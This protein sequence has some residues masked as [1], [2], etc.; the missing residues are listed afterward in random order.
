MKLIAHRG[1]FEG[2]SVDENSP[3]QIDLAITKGYDVE[4]DLWYD[5][6]LLL[7]H[8]FGQYEVDWEFLVNRRN[9]LWIHA[10]N[11][12]ALEYCL[13]RNLHVFFHDRDHY[14]VTSQGIGWAY[15]GMPVGPRTV[16]V[17]PEL[18]PGYTFTSAYGVCSD[19]LRGFQ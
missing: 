9:K 4:V 15:A 10:K 14:T 3:Y 13:V 18:V 6:S 1:N 2:R 11:H 7:G 12:G 16:A 8:D 5:G 19:D 17:M